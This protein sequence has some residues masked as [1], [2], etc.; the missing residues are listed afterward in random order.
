MG[1]LWGVLG[2][3]RQIINEI[4]VLLYEAEPNGKPTQRAHVMHPALLKSYSRK[5]I[6]L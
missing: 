5:L 6:L 2:S 4:S 1:A 3:V